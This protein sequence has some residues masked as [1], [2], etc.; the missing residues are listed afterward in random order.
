MGLISFIE[1]RSSGSV[2]DPGMWIN[3]LLESSNFATKSGVNITADTALKIS[4]VYACVTILADTLASLPMTIN[5]RL[6]GGGNEIAYD[7]PLF[8]I[9]HDNFN[10]E[11]TSY[12]AREMG[13]GH[14]ELRGNWYN[15]IERNGGGEIIGLWP[16][17]PVGMNVFRSGNDIWY[18]YTP[19]NI[20]R[21]ANRM[22]IYASNEIWHIKGFSKDGLTGLSKIAYARES[23]GLTQALQDYSGQFFANRATPGAIVRH[24]GGLKPLARAN[25]KESLQEYATS[26]RHTTLVL[27][28]GMEWI[29]VGLTNKDAQYLE[30]SN[31]Q[32]RDIARW[33]N[34]PLILLQEPDKVSTYASVE[35]FMLSF[36]IHSMVTPL[37]A[38][39]EPSANR[40]LLTEAERKA[41]Y[42]VKL[43]VNG[44][45]RGDFKTRMEGY[46]IARLNGLKN[47]DEIR[48]LEDEPP[49]PDGKGKL[50]W[51]PLNYKI[52]GEKS[53]PPKPNP[54][55]PKSEEP[56]EKEEDAS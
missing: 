35:Q 25:L 45:L 14:L 49:I 13:I 27:E 34:V 6:P 29:S 55:Q 19:G 10:V 40:A 56:E 33:F 18:Q 53:P 43:N 51:Q 50:Y 36:V 2:N 11:Q 46:Q 3:T 26:K 21:N 20:E 39:V 37:V 7:H 54:F 5:R 30:L 8:P 9:L 22:R 42:Y 24:P 47:G 32:V 44:L 31:A 16:L 1:S 38:R 17:N 48:A 15:R 28:E 23:M 4:T 41:G 12:E 52:L